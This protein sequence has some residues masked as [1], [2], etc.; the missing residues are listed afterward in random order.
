MISFLSKELD[1]M[2]LGGPVSRREGILLSVIFHLVVL[3]VLI[4]TPPLPAGKKSPAMLLALQRAAKEPPMRFVYMAPRRD[5]EAKQPPKTDVNSDKNRLAQSLRP[6][7]DAKN[8]LPYS[9][10]NTQE[11]VEG[12]LA[13]RARLRGAPQ[14]QAPAAGAPD[15]N[16]RATAHNQP[17]PAKPAEQGKNALLQLPP[18]FARRGLNGRP[19]VPPAPPPGNLGNALRNLDRYVRAENFENQAGG[20][21]GNFGPSIQFDS[22]GV[23]FGPWIRRFVAQIRRN[24]LIPYAAMAMKGH[25]IVTFNVHKDGALTD[26]TVVGPSGIPAFDNSSYDALAA[27]NPTY[28]LPPEY[29]ADR[30]FF[31]VTFYYNEPVP[32]Y[33]PQQ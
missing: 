10:G 17:E 4:V 13:E 21:N 32:S 9:R 2:P 28:P 7:P 20:A 24:W 6:N 30:A 15:Q 1:L 22:K 5:I 33:A 31:T 12:S 25:V 26:L 3:I 23:E 14:K 11:R 16:G 18:D 19:D 8:A 29:P 27:S